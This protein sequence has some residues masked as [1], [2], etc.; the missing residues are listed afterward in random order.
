[1]D[2]DTTRNALAMVAEAV[3][4]LNEARRG[5]C[6]GDL[7]WVIPTWVIPSSGFRV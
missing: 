6:G 1:M 3:K 7:G 2:Q 4:L 5:I